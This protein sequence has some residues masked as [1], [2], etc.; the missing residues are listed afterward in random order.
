MRWYVTIN[1]CIGCY[2]DI[3]AY[4]NFPHDCRI[5]TYPYFITYY[6]STFSFASVLLPNSDSFVDIYI[7]TYY[8][9]WID[10]DIIKMSKI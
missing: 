8:C 1:I 7:F 10:C 2:K 5:N 9:M 6:R 3:V 4:S